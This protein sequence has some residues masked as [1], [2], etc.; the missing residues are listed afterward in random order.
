MLDDKQRDAPGCYKDSYPE[1]CPIGT[2]GHDPEAGSNFSA[3]LNYYFQVLKLKGNGKATDPHGGG[4]YNVVWVDARVTV[5][6]VAPDG[7]D[8][9]WHVWATEA[10]FWEDKGDG[11]VRVDQNRPMV[12]D[13]VIERHDVVSCSEPS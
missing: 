10:E 13:V 8:C 12:L 9:R 11:V 1:G 6:G 2:S 3:D 7:T 5:D 4:A